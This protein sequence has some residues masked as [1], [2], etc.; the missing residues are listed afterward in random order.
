M[1]SVALLHIG[2]AACQQVV[3]D[4]FAVIILCICFTT[5]LI[6]NFMHAWRGP[7]RICG[8]SR[9]VREYSRCRPVRVVVVYKKACMDVRLMHALH[10]S[11]L[12][13]SIARLPH[14]LHHDSLLRCCSFVL[15][16]ASASSSWCLLPCKLQGRIQTNFRQHMPPGKSSGNSQQVSTA[17]VPPA[18]TCSSSSIATGT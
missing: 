9:D 8:V 16:P 18:S 14:V 10:A 12:R 6:T 13:S 2:E 17:A 7:W 3:R 4:L 5:R 1:I 15:L 11:M